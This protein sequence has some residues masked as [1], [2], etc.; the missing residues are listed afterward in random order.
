MTPLKMCS[1]TQNGTKGRSNAPKKSPRSP[2]ISRHQTGQAYV[3]LGGHRH[4]LGRYDESAAHEKGHRLIAEFLANGKRLRVEP[5]AVTVTE[6]IAAYLIHVEDTYRRHDGTV[7][8]DTVANITLALDTAKEFYGTARVVEFGP[9]A[10]RACVNA[11]VASGKRRTTVNKRLGDLK[12]LFKWGVSMEMI[13]PAVFHGLS[14]VEGLRHGRCT[15]KESR[16]V[17]AVAES[18]VLALQSHVA[19][20]VWGLIRLQWLSGARSGEILKLRRCDI[21]T[22][23]DPTIAYRSNF[24]QADY[25]TAVDKCVEINFTSRRRTKLSSNHAHK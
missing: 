22:T 10:L 20:P 18:H 19:R 5:Q 8:R 1:T 12:R 9:L 11:W 6:L 4:Y 15:A 7:N 16:V 25:Q 3:C 2:K 23:G 13:P 17:V 14:T 24:A 21:D